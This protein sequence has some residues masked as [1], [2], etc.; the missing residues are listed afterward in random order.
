MYDNKISLSHAWHDQKQEDNVLARGSCLFCV[1]CF[2][3]LIKNIFKIIFFT[4][5]IQ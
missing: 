4:K 3:N 1:I 5:E 2:A